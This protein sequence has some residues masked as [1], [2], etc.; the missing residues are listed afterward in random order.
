MIF[1]VIN[2][3]NL[4]K[5]IKWINSYLQPTPIKIKKGYRIFFGARDQKGVSRPGFI[6]IKNFETSNIIHFSKKP[7]M[8][9]GPAGCFDDNG[10][11][12]TFVFNNRQKIYMYYAGYQIPKKN[13][14]LAF[15]GLAL[16][17]K[18]KF[19]R[20]SD[21]PF[22]DR[23]KKN[24]LFNV[25]HFVQ[26]YKNK[27][28]FYYGFGN[29]TVKNTP[30]YEIGLFI[31]NIRKNSSKTVINLN[32]SKKEIRVGRPNIYK[33][34]NNFYMFFCVAT[35]KSKFHIEYAVSKNLK[36]WKRKGKITLRGS[37]KFK[38]MYLK[39]QAYPYLIG[40]KKNIYM[41]FNGNDY[42]KDGI[43]VS[44]LIKS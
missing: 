42:G 38:K 11:V 10:I 22:L 44:R 36:N 19:I 40:D 7:L 43:L 4:Y 12:P 14:F 41:L 32:K 29:S 25:I 21:T 34:K 30:S 2:K 37:M 9:I 27:N 3:I 15:T 23:Q 26:K 35:P 17:R 8:D 1:E 6:D 18:D 5:K 20:T 24:Y 39:M 16:K 31:D 28:Y 13:K 33:I